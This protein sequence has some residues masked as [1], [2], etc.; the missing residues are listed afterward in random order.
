MDTTLYIHEATRQLSN[1]KYY[2]QISQPVTPNIRTAIKDILLNLHT[3]SYINRKQLKFLTS[4]ISDN[5]PRTFYLL[6]KIHKPRDTW[7][8]PSMP[9]G[10]P[11][12][13]DTNS[14]THQLSRFIDYY[15]RPLANQ[16]PSYIKDTYD[17]VSK[18]NQQTIPI[19]ALLVTADVTALYTN[20]HHDTIIDTIK[21]KFAA[22]PDHKRPDT[23]I[24]QLLQL[25]LKN[26]DFTFNNNTYLQT[27]GAAMGYPTSPS[28]ADIYLE[29]FDSS[30]TS[31]YHDSIQLYFRFL[32]DI[33]FTWTG[34]LDQLTDLTTFA[35]SI[36]PDIHIT[37]TV[38]HHSITFLD[39]TVY[40]SYNTQDDQHA[41]LNT[42]IYFK[43]TD[44]HQLLHKLSHH[45]RHTT[46]GLLKSQFIR[47]KRISSN[48]I[49]YNTA[50]NTLWQSLKNR[51]YS[52]SR[53][54][55]L[56]RDTYNT[57]K[58]KTP[59]IQNNDNS[60][61]PIVT[62]YDTASQQ[63][64]KYIRTQLTNNPAFQNTKLLSAY[65]NHK[66]LH[67]FLVSSKVN[68]YNKTNTATPSIHVCNHPK[69]LCCQ[70]LDTDTHYH[71]SAHTKTFNIKRNFT[72]NSQHVIY[73]I[74][75]KQC[76]ILY[77]GL[78]DRKLKDRLTDHRS[79]TILHKDTPIAIHFNQHGLDNLQIKP[80]FQLYNN[81]SYQNKLNT[82]KSF[83]YTL[84]TYA[85]FGLNHIKTSAYDFTHLI[86]NTQNNNTDNNSQRDTLRNINSN[87]NP[88][89][90]PDP[91]P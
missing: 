49:Q 39:T 23:H 10:R 57:Y 45:P 13:S 17:F 65:K 8:H 78:T 69:C 42:K 22:N 56:K 14:P 31:T 29:H 35:N 63:L 58:P 88:N 53:Y 68:K 5:T 64:N 24:L 75:C 11:I 48:F 18:I 41:Q 61:F 71:N 43:S 67:N 80:I 25:L 66:S 89:T 73:L 74:T 81:T 59:N 50:C 83:I 20:M 3:H 84:K 54:R 15:L 28:C 16:H 47:F 62:Y 85:P 4:H 34:T 40:K 19:N 86:P 44:T 90:N 2:K 7:P 51:G 26:N 72:C 27:I 33:F 87:P 77:I 70:H 6:P 82:E 79:N 1:S 52:S 32:D 12:V 9:P 36:I 46:I 76:N 38:R 37:L 55:K 91:N 21:Q 60:I 30:L